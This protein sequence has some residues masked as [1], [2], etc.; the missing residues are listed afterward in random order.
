MSDHH[1][2]STQFLSNVAFLLRECVPEADTDP[3]DM[4]AAA[5][6]AER[7]ASWIRELM[8]EGAPE[9][10]RVDC[11]LPATDQRDNARHCAYHLPESEA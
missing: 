2:V 3:D 9:C 10:D 6:V 5:R 1:V 11:M 7:V 8:P 4:A